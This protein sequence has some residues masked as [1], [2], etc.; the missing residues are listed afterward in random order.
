MTL[1]RQ[2][3]QV[4]TV[5]VMNQYKRMGDMLLEKG[6]LTSV[7]LGRALECQETTR[8]RFGEVVVSLGFV[9]EHEITSCLAEQYDLP[10]A[11]LNEIKSSPEVLQLITPT[12][13]L[14][15]LFLPVSI[16]ETE[17]VGVIADPIDIDAT[18]AVTQAVGKRLRLSIAPPT[19]LFEFIAKTYAIPA[20]RRQL[21]VEEPTA[22][23]PKRKM[24]I[25]KQTD[26][27][28]LLNSLRAMKNK[29]VKI[30]A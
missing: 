5:S 16:S 1:S 20:K 25:D 22:E 10:I 26:R 24:R 12:F 8:R 18:D 2:F 6:L 13:A 7:Q 15:H 21:E 11:N 19:A 30:A 14:R 4:T 23:K 17:I 27:Q 3:Q 28:E 9:E 29:R